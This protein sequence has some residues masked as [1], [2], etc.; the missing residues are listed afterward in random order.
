MAR[1]ALIRTAT[2][3]VENVIELEPGANWA[4]P[5]G[6]FT[7]DAD[8]G[9]PGDT[10]DGTRFVKP[11]TPPP[12]PDRKAELRAEVTAATTFGELKAAIL[13]GLNTGGFS[14]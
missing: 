3:L 12:P 5:A 10:W 6:Y 4:A 8:D 14:S 2:G 13:T 11:P 1:M 7:R 9:G